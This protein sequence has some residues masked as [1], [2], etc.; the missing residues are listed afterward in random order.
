MSMTENEAIKI[1]QGAIK[2]PNTQDG[3]LGQA[4][5]MAIQALEKVQQ[6]EAIGTVEEFKMLKDDLWKLNEICKDYSA[7]GTV[8]EFKALKEKSVPKKPDFTEDKQF[9]LC[10]NISCNSKGLK[11]K[12]KYCDC[13]GQKLDWQ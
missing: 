3:Y 13:C 6:Y 4:V 12:Q 11:D 8:E 1:L 9:A 5:T 2:K 7:I 10:P